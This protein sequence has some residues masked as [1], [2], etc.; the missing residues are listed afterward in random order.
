MSGLAES[1]LMIP[2]MNQQNIG[3]FVSIF[4]QSVSWIWLRLTK[5]GIRAPGLLRCTLCNRSQLRLNLASSDRIKLSVETVPCDSN[6]NKIPPSPIIKSNNKCVFASSTSDRCFQYLWNI[7]VM[8]RKNWV[9]LISIVDASYNK[10]GKKEIKDS[11]RTTSVRLTIVKGDSNF[12]SGY[13][14]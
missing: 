10:I 5:S 11:L 12:H 2:K 4:F 3:K 14:I 9:N 13:N 7:F 8:I 1:W 6:N